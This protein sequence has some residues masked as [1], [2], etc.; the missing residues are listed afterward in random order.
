[1][2]SNKVS[3]T[4]QQKEQ[5]LAAINELHHDWGF[6]SALEEFKRM[7]WFSQSHEW[8]NHAPSRVDGLAAFQHIYNLFAKSEMILEKKE[9]CDLFEV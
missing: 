3:L 9:A 8:Y 1:M 4:A 2:S 5:L 7:Y 6:A